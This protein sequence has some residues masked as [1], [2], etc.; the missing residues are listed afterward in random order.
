MANLVDP[1]NVL[2]R[3]LQTGSMLGC[4]KEGAQRTTLAH[5]GFL[6]SKLSLLPSGS[7]SL[8]DR[9]CPLLLISPETLGLT[10]GVV[11]IHLRNVEKGHIREM[12]H[13]VEIQVSSVTGMVYITSLEYK[14]NHL[15]FTYSVYC[16]STHLPSGT[17][18][19]PKA[20]PNPHTWAGT[21]GKRE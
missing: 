15:T 5:A 19:F 13:L 9:L 14:H 3:W 4:K 7:I 6:L 20:S 16:L 10:A 21:L 17:P 8:R 12:T 1:A 18:L 11:G 2:V